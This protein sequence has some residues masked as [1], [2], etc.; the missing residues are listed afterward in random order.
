M[1]KRDQCLFNPGCGPC[2]DNSWYYPA[3]LSIHIAIG[4]ELPFW[5]HQWV[6]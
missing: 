2:R 1:A 5:K 4:E 6:P 3:F